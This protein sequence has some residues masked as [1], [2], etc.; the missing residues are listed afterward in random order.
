MPPMR[1]SRKNAEPHDLQILRLSGCTL[2][3]VAQFRRPRR[4]ARPGYDRS[5]LYRHADGRFG[6]RMAL[7]RGKPGLQPLLRPRGWARRSTRAGGAPRLACRQELLEG[8]D[9][10][11]FLFDRNRDRQ[12]GSPGRSAG[13]SGKTDRGSCGIVSGLR[14]PLVDRARESARTQ[15]YRP[16]SQGRSGRKISLAHSSSRRGRALG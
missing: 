3:A 6:A 15:R 16:H 4:P 2:H 1:R 10:Y 13:L 5:A 8:R 12:P 11:Q 14:R 7:P 9:R